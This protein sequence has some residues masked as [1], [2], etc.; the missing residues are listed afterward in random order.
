VYKELREPTYLV[1]TALAG[2]RRHGYA[3][4][5]DVEELSN[6]R[7]VLRAGTLYAMIERLVAEGLVTPAGEE[8]VDGRLRRYYALSDAGADELRSA[9]QRLASAAHVALSRLEAA[10][11]PPGSGVPPG[12][13]VAW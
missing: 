8:V 10:S 12:L 9:S 4:I 5:K 13:G 2:V 7:V 1:L 6:G 3:L 11:P